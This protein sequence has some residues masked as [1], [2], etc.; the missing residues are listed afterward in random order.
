MDEH[1]KAFAVEYGRILETVWYIRSTASLEV[2][3]NYMNQILSANDRIAVVEAKDMWMRNL[4]IKGD[5]IL[6]A[7]PK[8]A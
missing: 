5:S 4:L 2:L 6:E 1:I 3:S 7:W 8:A